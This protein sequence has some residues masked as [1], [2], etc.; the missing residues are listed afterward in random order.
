MTGRGVLSAE[1]RPSP[2]GDYFDGAVD[3]LDG[4]L[5]VDGVGRGANAGGP[6]LCVD[7]GVPRES[8]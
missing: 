1:L 3:D 6:S 2:F 5:V 4:R 8:A 7:Q